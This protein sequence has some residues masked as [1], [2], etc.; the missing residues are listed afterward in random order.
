GK[1]SVQGIFPLARA[2]A[3]L[4]LTT[5][6]FFSP[7]GQ[8]ISNVGVTPDVV[9]HEVAKAGYEKILSSPDDAV[10]KAAISTAL[11]KIAAR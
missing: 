6:K 4:R 8:P 11:H 1:G 3:G 9:V 5:A 10:L 7:K 2:G